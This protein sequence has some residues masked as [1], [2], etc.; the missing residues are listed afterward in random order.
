L[1]VIV[2][3]LVAETLQDV[4]QRLDASLILIGHDMGLQAQMSDRIGV[5]YAGRLVEVGSVRAIFK[6]PVHPYTQL[7][8]ASI[9]SIK[10]KPA[11]RLHSGWSELRKEIFPDN[12]ILTEVEPDHFVAMQEDNLLGDIDERSQD[13]YADL[14]EEE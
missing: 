13:L 11:E 14:I 6:N 12:P 7:L 3:R 1:D 9:P 4:Q 10:K 2:Q 5:M 8:I